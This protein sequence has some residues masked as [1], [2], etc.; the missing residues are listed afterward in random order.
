M[1]SSYLLEKRLELVERPCN[2]THSHMN[3]Y[4]TIFLTYEAS[5]KNNITTAPKPTYRHADNTC[6]A[7]EIILIK[8]LS[9]P[10]SVSLL[11]YL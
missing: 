10:A 9:A 7:Y 5:I 8:I 6:V 1:R 3:T 11:F 2:C 4:E